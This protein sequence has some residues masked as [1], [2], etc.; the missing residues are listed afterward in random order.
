M[1][2]KYFH[3]SETQL[4]FFAKMEAKMGRTYKVGTVIYS[5]KRKSF[6]DMTS[7]KESIYSDDKIVAEGDTSS[8]TYTA[9]VRGGK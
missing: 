7:K 1:A 8:I 2:Y 9:P 4:Q 5:G 6:T 3:Y